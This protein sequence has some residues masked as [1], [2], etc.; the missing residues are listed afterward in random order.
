MEPPTTIVDV[1]PQL[2]K[3]SGKKLLDVGCGAGGLVR[4]L[5]KQ[6][7]GVY[8]IEPCADKVELARQSDPENAANYR[9]SRAEQ[10]P[11]DDE[12][13]DLVIFSNSL[14]HVPVALQQAALT[15]C[16]RVLKPG[17]HAVIAEPVP[18][19]AHFNLSLPME[20]ETE[21]RNHALAAIL[22]T[23]SH[24][25]EI[26]QENSFV[27]A[28]PYAN[29][30]AYHKAMILVDL[31]REQAF[32]DRGDDLR[33]GFV[34]YARREGDISFFDQEIRVHVLRKHLAD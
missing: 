5:S 3:V 31:A 16:A 17:G 21:V 32:I 7:A 29:F 14:H 10:L 24:G 25:M 2:V 12:E 13:F 11:F 23:A 8:G 1:I 33:Q 26:R 28:T 30:E 20:D 4:A 22:D 18:E 19:G 34:R 15:E 9:V 6:G 27:R